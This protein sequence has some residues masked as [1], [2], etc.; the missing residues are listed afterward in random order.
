MYVNYGKQQLTID[1]PDAPNCEFS[2]VQKAGY[3]RESNSRD[4]G[5]AKYKFAF[6]VILNHYILPITIT[7][8]FYAR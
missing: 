7:K 5:P 4:Q 6:P 3:S 1:A 8:T 2:T